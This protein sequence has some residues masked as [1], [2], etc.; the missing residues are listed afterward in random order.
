M[1]VINPDPAYAPLAPLVGGKIDTR[2]IEPHR[3]EVL[4]LG[5]SIG[6][7]LVPP[8]VILKKIAAT[9]RQNG[10]SLALREIGRIERSIFICDWLLDPKLRRRSHA[11]LN[12]GES[13]HALA[14]AVFLHQLGEL[15]NRITETMAH[16]ASGLNFVVNAIILW[17]T[18]Y[19]SRAV[20]F[21]AD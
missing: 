13:R 1:F 14:R 16:R 20:H 7:G 3:D 17:D 10:L 5:A 18:V 8:S 15:S 4:R 12:K 11:I 2:R 21:V 19:L 9:P 6:S